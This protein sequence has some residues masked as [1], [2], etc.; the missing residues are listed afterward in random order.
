MTTRE[1]DQRIFHNHINQLPTL[2]P[3]LRKSLVFQV[4]L[5]ILLVREDGINTEQCR[6][7]GRSQMPDFTT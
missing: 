3:S 2:Y 6:I 1:A 5:P 7:N 4:M